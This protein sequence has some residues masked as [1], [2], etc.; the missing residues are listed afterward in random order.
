MAV[1]KSGIK[2]KLD[3]EMILYIT[4]QILFARTISLKK[5]HCIKEKGSVAKYEKSSIESVGATI[6]RPR[7]VNDR[8]YIRRM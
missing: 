2:S 4:M 5:Q 1:G 8:P 6:S 3:M 7:A